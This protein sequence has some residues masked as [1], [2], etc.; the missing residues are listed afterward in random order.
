MLS[1]RQSQ[2]I[3]TVKPFRVQPR[4]IYMKDKRDKLLMSTEKHGPQEIP[5]CE[6]GYWGGFSP[7]RRG[8]YE[9][10]NLA[11]QYPNG[12]ER[13][14]PRGPKLQSNLKKPGTPKRFGPGGNFESEGE[15]SPF[16]GRMRVSTNIENVNFELAKMQ[17]EQ[18]SYEK[19]SE[20]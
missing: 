3:K 14:Y 16:G 13:L 7:K 9:D 12:R 15:E 10:K 6:H 19:I 20:N 17:V 5:E 2:S 4:V 8:R 1:K 18:Q 11:R